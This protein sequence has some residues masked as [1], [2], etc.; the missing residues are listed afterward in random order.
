MLI[1]F[2]GIFFLLNSIPLSKSFDEGDPLYP[3]LSVVKRRHSGILAFE[4]F[5]FILLPCPKVRSMPSVGELKSW[6]LSLLVK[7]YNLTFII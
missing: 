3:R 4:Q 1:T 7:K 2:Y 5:S 6:S